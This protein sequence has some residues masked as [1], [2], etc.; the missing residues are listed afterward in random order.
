MGNTQH[1]KADNFEAGYPEVPSDI[2]P[3]TNVEAIIPFPAVNPSEKA[4]KFYFEGSSE[5][6]DIN[7][8]PF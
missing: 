7:I 4:I 5:N 8:E 2:L 6:Y 1:E 3:K